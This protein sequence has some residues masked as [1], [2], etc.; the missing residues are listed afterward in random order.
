MPKNKV[1]SKKNQILRLIFIFGLMLFSILVF[2][3]E[4]GGGDDA[5]FPELSKNYSLLGWI[6]FRYFSWSGRIIA[7]AYIYIMGHLSIQFWRICNIF[8]YGMLSFFLYKYYE[9][10][11]KNQYEKLN[12]VMA[13][14]CLILPFGMNFGT[15]CDSSF[16]VTGSL[17][18]LWIATA[19]IAAFYPLLSFVINKKQP[20]WIYICLGFIFAFAASTSQEQVSVVLVMLCVI[21]ILYIFFVLKKIPLFSIIE[22]A[23]VITGFLI[24]LLSPGNKSRSISEVKNYIPDFFNVSILKRFEYS[25]RW[26]LDALINHLGILLVLI[27][28]FILIMLI[29]K[30]KKSYIDSICIVDISISLLFILFK[31][32]IL[33]LFNFEAKWGIVSFERGSYI[34]V[35]FWSVFLVVILIAAVSLFDFKIKGFSVSLIILMSYISASVMILS[36]TMYASGCRTMFVSSIIL[37][38]AILMLFCDC[39]EKYNNYSY[40]IVAVTFAYPV[41]QYLKFAQT[42]LTAYTYH[43]PW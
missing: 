11:R 24:N 7:E 36:P 8:Q 14:L 28:V 9:L 35:I 13:A 10:F 21:S 20:N 42:F 3:V 31:Y 15:M 17:V 29:K 33:W 27:S 39:I 41:Y 1:F 32:E 25:Y 16:W 4:R 34:P 5:K 38:I 18:Y 23:I 19:G 2:C 26:I 22:T 37:C 12:Y 40:L 43:F 30:I 6:K